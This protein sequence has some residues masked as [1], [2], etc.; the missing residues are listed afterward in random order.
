M[1]IVFSAYGRQD[2][3]EADRLGIKYLH[4]AG[5]NPYASI[6]T[7]QT[8]QQESKGVGAPTVLR[9]HP[10]IPDRIE[11]AKKEIQLISEWPPSLR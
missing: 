8:L 1:N 6:T 2:E 7:L 5:Y 11:T 4:L 3:Y 10:H 9:N